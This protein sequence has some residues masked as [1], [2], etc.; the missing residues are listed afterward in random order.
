MDYKSY[1]KECFSKLN[2]FDRT[3]KPW[4]K[5]QNVKLSDISPCSTCEVSKELIARQYEVQ[6]SGGLQ[7]EIMQPC[8]HCL[9]NV[10]WRIECIE[11]LKWYE[12]NDE[13]L[14]HEESSLNN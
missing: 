14:K 4:K 9:D 13:R 2:N 1:R 6:M 12:E 8:E 11:K 3:F 7:E 5:W 10:L